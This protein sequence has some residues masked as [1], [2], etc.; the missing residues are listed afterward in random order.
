MRRAS[1]L[2]SEITH[3]P[4]KLLYEGRPMVGMLHGENTPNCG[5]ET[6]PKQKKQ[7]GSQAA[8]KLHP[9]MALN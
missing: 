3:C 4:D 7:N 1:P 6:A 9:I 8:F 2:L 5:S